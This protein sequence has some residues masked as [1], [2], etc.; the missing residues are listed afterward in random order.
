LPHTRCLQARKS[1]NGCTFESG[2]SS[3][4]KVTTFTVGADDL[5]RFR[6]WIDASY[7][8][9]PD[10]R[11]HTG[12]A[13]SFGRGAIACKSTK[14]KLNT[15]SSTEAETVGASDYLPN[16]IWIKM[17]M[18]A[19]GYHISSSILEQDN[20]SAIKLAKNGRTSA[21]PKSRH[22]DIRYFWLKDRIKSGAIIIRHCPTAQML[23]DFFTKPLQGHLFRRFKAVVL[24]HQH[25]DS[26]HDV[27][28]VPLEERVGDKQSGTSDIPVQVRFHADVKADVTHPTY[29]EVVKKMYVAKPPC[30][31]L[32]DKQFTTRKNILSREAH[33]LERIQ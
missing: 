32:P 33:S 18:E 1:A 11:S 27:V 10:C 3:R 16:T 13:I 20:E 7:A 23:A 30:K 26:L 21:G 9:H 29:A 12:G 14:Q 28:A 22:I 4:A 15:K 2:C 31:R 8:V 17:F 5:G 24:G 6:T 25:V 19:Q